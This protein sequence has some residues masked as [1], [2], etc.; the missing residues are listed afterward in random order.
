MIGVKP[1]CFKCKH[2]Y[3]N[4]LGA[5]CAAFSEG[6]PEEIYV[7]QNKHTSPL[8]EQDNDLVFSQA[9]PQELAK[10]GEI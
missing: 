5:T 6:I 1:V 8:D 4:Q 3:Y 10:R 9:N 7:Y 2:F